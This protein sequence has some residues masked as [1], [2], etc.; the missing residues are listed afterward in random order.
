MEGQEGATKKVCSRRRRQSLTHFARSLALLADA[1]V[2]KERNDSRPRKRR[3][4]RQA[5]GQAGERIAHADCT[6]DRQQMAPGE[7][8]FIKHHR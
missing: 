2:G 8:R 6:C 1:A 5:G 7:A 3:A 4:G